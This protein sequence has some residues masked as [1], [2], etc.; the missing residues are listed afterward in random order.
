MGNSTGIITLTDG[1]KW[2]NGRNGHYVRLKGVETGGIGNNGLWLFK[3][4]DATHAQLTLQMEQFNSCTVDGMG[5]IVIQ[6]PPTTLY[7]SKPRNPF[8]VGDLQKF[9]QMAVAY[10]RSMLSKSEGVLARPS[11]KFQPSHTYSLNRIP[12]RNFHLRPSSS[13]KHAFESYAS[14][15]FKLL[16]NH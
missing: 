1:T 13:W 11:R 10:R 16:F 2:Y 4:I 7:R 3:R 9:W 15:D 6:G 12:R 5:K 14:T 8:S